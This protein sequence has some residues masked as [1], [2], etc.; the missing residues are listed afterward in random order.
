MQTKNF[1]SDLFKFPTMD[2]FQTT[3]EEAKTRI[4]NFAQFT[5][6]GQNLAATSGTR[7]VDLMF[8]IHLGLEIHEA[9]WLSSEANAIS[10]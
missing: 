9:I 10:H 1:G 3:T 8:D 7:S 6:L 4:P 5:E 2:I